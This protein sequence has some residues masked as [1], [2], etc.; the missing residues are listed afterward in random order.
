MSENL[1]IGWSVSGEVM[2]LTDRGDVPLRILRNFDKC[3]D[4]CSITNC[5]GVKWALITACYYRSNFVCFT[6]AN[7][8]LFADERKKLLSLKVNIWKHLYSMCAITLKIR[9]LQSLQ[10][11][12]DL[13][14]LPVNFKYRHH[15]MNRN[16]SSFVLTYWFYQFRAM[17][18]GKTNIFIGGQRWDPMTSDSNLSNT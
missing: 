4:V 1:S 7:T 13:L 15:E 9:Y 11:V 5:S 18:A 10:H 12:L 16:N 3:L 14:S 2:G 8:D 6:P 17:F